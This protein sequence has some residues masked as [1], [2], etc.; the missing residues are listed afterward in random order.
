MTVQNN[1]LTLTFIKEVILQKETLKAFVAQ[2]SCA[3]M[4]N[5]QQ[6][7]KLTDKEFKELDEFVCTEEF[8]KEFLLEIENMFSSKELTGLIKIYTSDL[9]TKFISNGMPMYKKISDKIIA[10]LN[11][12]QAAGK[13]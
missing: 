7:L 12:E 9:Y 10:H 3:R 5:L 6:A 1:K 4:V 8:L 11:P 2:A 13:L